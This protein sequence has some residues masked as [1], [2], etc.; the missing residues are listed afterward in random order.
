M[1]NISSSFDHR[2]VDGHEAAKFIQDL[3]RVLETPRGLLR[4][5]V[6]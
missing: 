3:K 5:Q 4:S 6:C 2:I 1:M